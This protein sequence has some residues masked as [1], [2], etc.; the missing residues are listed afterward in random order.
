MLAAAFP[1]NLDAVKALQGLPNGAIAA[2]PLGVGV[3]YS[4]ITLGFNYKKSLPDPLGAILI[5]PEVRY[6]HASVPVFNNGRSSDSFTIGADFI[7][8]F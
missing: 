5:R 1:G 8:S 4:E 6:D 3:T 7:L 2:A